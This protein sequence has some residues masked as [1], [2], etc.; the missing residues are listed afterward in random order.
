[1]PIFALSKA[2]L[3]TTEL[4]FK[5]NLVCVEKAAVVT[6]AFL[7]ALLLMNSFSRRFLISL[8]TIGY[9]KGTKYTLAE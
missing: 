5:L 4:Q 6:V 8:Y 9:K 2:N 3:E 1:M 7:I